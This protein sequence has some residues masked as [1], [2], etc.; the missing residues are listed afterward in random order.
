MIMMGSS[1][2]IQQPEKKN[3]NLTYQLNY[4]EF[5]SGVLPDDFLAE[6]SPKN[7][8]YNNLYKQASD[9]FKNIQNDEERKKVT[10]A[11]FA[12]VFNDK[13]N[14]SLVKQIQETYSFKA[15]Q[16]ALKEDN[17]ITI[18]PID[19]DLSLLIKNVENNNDQAFVEIKQKIYLDNKEIGCICTK[20]IIPKN[21]TSYDDFEKRAKIE[22]L[23]TFDEP[24][25]SE[26]NKRKNYINQLI[27]AFE[28]I[29]DPVE[30]DFGDFQLIS[31]T[32]HWDNNVEFLVLKEKAIPVAW[33]FGGNEEARSLENNENDHLIKD[34]PRINSTLDPSN[35]YINGYYI[36][37]NG[38]AL[39][40]YLL[41]FLKFS[42]QVLL[43]LKRYYSQ[44]FTHC[45]K[46][47]FAFYKQI[48]DEAKSN[49]FSFFER[50]LPIILPNITLENRKPVHEQIDESVLIHMVNI[51]SHGE[52]LITQLNN[53]T[54]EFINHESALK[55]TLKPA[56]QE[57][58]LKDLPDNNKYSNIGTIGEDFYLEIPGTVITRMI[59]T[60]GN[61]FDVK[62]I[63][64]SNT[65]L[66][67]LIRRNYLALTVE[68]YKF[69]KAQ[70]E[71][72]LLIKNPDHPIE[73]DRK[74]KKLLD[75]VQQS[76]EK[77]RTNKNTSRQLKNL[78]KELRDFI[79]QNSPD[80]K[81]V[82]R[83][84]IEE[85]KERLTYAHPHEL[86]EQQS[87]TSQKITQL[88]ALMAELESTNKLDATIADKLKQFSSQDSSNNNPINNEIFNEFAERP[89]KPENLDLFRTILFNIAYFFKV[90]VKEWILGNPK[91]SNFLKNLNEYLSKFDKNSNEIPNSN[92]SIEP[93]KEQSS[94]VY[95]QEAQEVLEPLKSDPN[96]NENQ[97]SRRIANLYIESKK[98]AKQITESEKRI[99]SL[100]QKMDSTTSNTKSASAGQPP[101]PTNSS[102]Q[103]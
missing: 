76:W 70:E 2:T 12:F 66:T 101:S 59:A 23:V 103:I 3:V 50:M 63:K 18:N 85:E 65:F 69:A 57:H 82:L 36:G 10:D 62:E 54:L 9:V 51:Y 96:D 1:N 13:T 22:S 21:I 15:G 58:I 48:N 89:K 100:L 5:D 42:D 56:V 83:I 17:K 4:S 8:I 99:E 67:E 55:L 20:L 60:D 27:P 35:I 47:D 95:Q 38:T 43:S 87:I 92:S 44:G 90:T 74:A 86:R 75:K 68:H 41:N 77:I 29:L 26:L 81:Q 24:N 98:L 40:N 19:I 97:L 53:S 34:I 11:L 45:L 79:K 6:G 80:P 33:G 88:N 31:G 72:Q 102:Y 94:Q 7:E 61:N 28:S 78:T 93:S 39:P 25:Q 73:S 16:E 64:A 14:N 71:L 37:T 30:Y 91:S 32:T 49:F 52:W 84:M 46:A